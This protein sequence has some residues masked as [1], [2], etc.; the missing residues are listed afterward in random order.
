MA[1]VQPLIYSLNDASFFFVVD[2]VHA[3]SPAALSLLPWHVRRRLL[4][5]L[6]AADLWRLESCP[7]YSEGI[8]FEEVWKEL[9]ET[10]IF[11]WVPPQGMPAFQQGDG[12]TA[13]EA[14]LAY[15]TRVL[16]SSTREELSQRVTSSHFIPFPPTNEAS[17][18]ERREKM[19]FHLRRTPSGGGGGSESEHLLDKS[20]YIH[21]LLH[22]VHMVSGPPRLLDYLAYPF[23]SRRQYFCPKNTRDLDPTRAAQYRF[24]AS[25]REAVDAIAISGWLPT[26]LEIVAPSPELAQS[27]STRHV[28]KFLSSVREVTV[29]LTNDVGF[30]EIADALTALYRTEN[31]LSPTDLCIEAT[32]NY[33]LSWLLARLA[34]VCGFMT[35]Q[36]YCS[37]YKCIK[38]DVRPNGYNGLRRVSMRVSKVHQREHPVKKDWSII[39]CQAEIES[40]VLTRLKA[41]LPVGVCILLPHLIATR[42]SLK[43]VELVDCGLSCPAIEY[44]LIMFIT[45]PTSHA[46]TLTIR[47]WNHFYFEP[48][49]VQDMASCRDGHQKT[50][51][52]PFIPT[53]PGSLSWLLRCPELLLKSLEITIAESRCSRHLSQLHKV[54]EASKETMGFPVT[55]TIEAQTPSSAEQAN[56]PVIFDLAMC[57]QISEVRIM[58]V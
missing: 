16:L 7:K 56:A 10:H 2:N 27:L 42:P 28:L 54:L 44:L 25:Y 46:R 37:C 9:V 11:S 29:R 40:I 24:S 20:D 45:T 41:H 5:F 39:L 35:F 55:V 38:R 13:R 19:S 51:C 34:E 58:Q 3:F 15:L 23:D 52:I 1:D 50:L 22:G 31:G 36:D 43:H 53:G 12:E 4:E 30:P 6:P 47:Q 57:P 32:Y 49:C 21:L 8:D 48:L 18:H 14:F 26:G 33:Q 17:L